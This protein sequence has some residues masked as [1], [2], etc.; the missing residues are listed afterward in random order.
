MVKWR[1]A[2]QVSQEVCLLTRRAFHS[3][4][5]TLNPARVLHTASPLPARHGTYMVC[6]LKGQGTRV[7]FYNV[8]V[9]TKTSDR[10]QILRRCIFYA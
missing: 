8:R 4:R 3:R 1:D 10:R 2:C 6:G 7:C 9:G 5:G